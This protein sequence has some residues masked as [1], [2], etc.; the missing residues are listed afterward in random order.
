MKKAG[1]SGTSSEWWH[2]NA[3]SLRQAKQRYSIIP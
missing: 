3:C 1:F 2:F